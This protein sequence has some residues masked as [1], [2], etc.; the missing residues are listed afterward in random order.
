MAFFVQSSFFTNFNLAQPFPGFI[1]LDLFIPT[2][3]MLSF[4]LSA[5]DYL[6]NNFGFA[7]CLEKKPI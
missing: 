6:N 4:F 3:T 7:I 5:H 2:R 1:L